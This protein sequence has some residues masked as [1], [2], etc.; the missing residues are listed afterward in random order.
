MYSLFNLYSENFR[1]TI[2]IIC[3]LPTEHVFTTKESE[4]AAGGAD[5]SAALSQQME[6]HRKEH[7]KHLNALRDELAAKQEVID[8]LKECVLS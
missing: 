5:L 2:N 3:F 7:Q 8:G 4:A 6:E 1:C